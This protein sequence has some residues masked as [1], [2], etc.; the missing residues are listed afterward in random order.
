[1]LFADCLNGPGVAY[2]VGCDAADLEGGNDGDVDL[3]DFAVFQA[4]F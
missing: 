2:L 3:A 4:A 1:M